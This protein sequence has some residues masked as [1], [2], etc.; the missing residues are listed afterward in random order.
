[1]QEG[2]P[3]AELYSAHWT[4]LAL[5]TRPA[6]LT[7]RNLQRDAE[8]ARRVRD[9]ALHIIDPHSFPWVAR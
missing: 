6:T 9:L 4:W 5:D 7:P 8:E 2:E 1:M 3:R